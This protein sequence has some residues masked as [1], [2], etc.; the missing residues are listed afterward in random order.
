[1]ETSGREKTK[2]KNSL[3]Q[4]ETM[5]VRCGSGS[6]TRNYVGYLNEIMGL[7]KNECNSMMFK[8]SRERRLTWCQLEV[9]EKEKKKNSSQYIF[10]VIMT[11]YKFTVHGIHSAMCEGSHKQNRYGRIFSG[12]FRMCDV[13][14]EGIFVLSE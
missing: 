2:V 14:C 1:M 8:T 3:K 5:T 11:Q 9:Q 6:L 7:P 4:I 10:M 12:N 13:N